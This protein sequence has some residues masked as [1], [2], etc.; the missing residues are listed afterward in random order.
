[1]DR[2]FQCVLPIKGIAACKVSRIKLRTKPVENPRQSCFTAAAFARQN[3]Q[4]ALLN[5]QINVA[6][7]AVLT[8]VRIGEGNIL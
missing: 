4:F 6:Q 2:H 7:L 8:V 3:N 5:R 1:M